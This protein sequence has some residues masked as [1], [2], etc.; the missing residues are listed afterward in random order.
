MFPKRD[1]EETKRWRGVR[2]GE[3]EMEKFHDSEIWGG[4]KVGLYK[5]TGVGG[6]EEKKSF[7]SK[8]PKEASQ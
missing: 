4:G 5:K 7:P 8:N 6:Y 2:I 3:V 1:E